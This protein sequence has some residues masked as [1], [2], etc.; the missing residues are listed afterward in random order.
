[1]EYGQQLKKTPHTIG[2]CDMS[3]FG[4]ALI[5][6]MA[7]RKMG[8]HALARRSHYSAGYIS[9]L[10]NG[11][12]HPSPSAEP[13]LTRSSA[14]AASWPRW[15]HRASPRNQP[16]GRR[17]PAP[18]AQQSGCD[19]HDPVAAVD[20]AEAAARLAG[21]GTR[22]RA[23]GAA[24]QAHGHALAGNSAACLRTLDEARDIAAGP[25]D[26]PAGPWANWLSA[27]YVDIQRA[28]CLTALGGYEEAAGLFRETLVGIP[29]CCA[30]TAACT[31]PGRPSRTQVPR[32]RTA[33]LR[34]VSVRWL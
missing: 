34:Q 31:L 27:G 17:L 21:D 3:A 30:A 22:L 24:Y 20:L 8:V 11:T 18:T 29:R 12:R 2:I 6:L 10:R 7:D 26:D 23:A 16:P 28:R 15:P 19:M 14:L 33:R 9:N 4:E 1:M 13:S 5:R 32:T 25:D